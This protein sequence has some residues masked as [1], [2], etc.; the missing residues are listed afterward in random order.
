MG[1]DVTRRDL[2]RL[3][4]AAASMS[5]CAKTPATPV[6]SNVVRVA[7]VPTAVEGN[8]LPALFAEFEKDAPFKTELL[9]DSEPYALARA[10]RVDLA[11]SHYG[12]RDAEEFVLGGL[13]EWPRTLFSNQMALLGPPDDPAKIRGLDDAGE[14]FRRIAATKSP[15]IVN[16]IDGVAYLTEVLWHAAGRPERA[17]WLSDEGRR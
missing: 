5:A 16:H 14:A 13:G 15:F 9:S 2:I 11:V 7:S 6:A 1:D 10:G 8:I 12:H 3:S 17:G 4:L